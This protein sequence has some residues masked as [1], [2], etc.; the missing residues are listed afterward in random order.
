MPSGGSAQPAGRSKASPAVV[1]S[2]LGAT[3]GSGSS[4]GGGRAEEAF[5][6]AGLD[7]GRAEL[8]VRLV[9]TGRATATG[10]GCPVGSGSEGVQAKARNAAAIAA[11]HVDQ[12]IL[13]THR[14]PLKTS[15]SDRPFNPR[16]SGR[17]GFM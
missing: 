11:D 1:H 3:V 17:Q 5:V 13:R 15:D 10:E 9:G 8:S 6:A 14:T 12:R 2:R 7:V 4:E 16:G